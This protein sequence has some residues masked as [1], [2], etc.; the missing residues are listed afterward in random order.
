VEGCN[1][2]DV[3]T[4][5]Y[6]LDGKLVC[7]N[8]AEKKIDINCLPNAAYIVKVKTKKKLLTKKFIKY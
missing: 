5:I 2:N 6:S 7:K 4:E 1:S 8:I 3:V